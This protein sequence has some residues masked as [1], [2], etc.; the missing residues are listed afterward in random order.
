MSNRRFFAICSFMLLLSLACSSCSTAKDTI[1]SDVQS[2]PPTTASDSTT[3]MDDSE[4]ISTASFVKAG[5]GPL[6]SLDSGI[7]EAQIV[8]ENSCSIFYT[9]PIQQKRIYLCGAPNCTHDNESCSAY[10]STPGRTYPPML[11]TN[12]KK[13]LLMFTEALE[14]S[15][16]SMISIDLDGSNRQTVFELASN[17]YVRGNFYISND[18]IYFDV[19]QT[20]S[21]SSS[22]YQLW[23][24]NIESKEA[25]EVAD[26]GSDEQFYYL[27]GCAGS[28]LCFATIDS[29]SNIKYYLSTPQELNFDAPFYTDNSGHADSFVSNGF[30]YTISEEGECV[31]RT[32]LISGEKRVTAFPIKEGYSDPA[33]QYAYDNNLLVTEG[34]PVVNGKFDVCAYYIDF[35][36]DTATEISLRTPYNNRPVYVYATVG[37]KLY[38]ATDY[39]TYTVKQSFQDGGSE[40]YEYIAYEYAFILKK[41]YV[42]SNDAGY[43][44]VEDMFD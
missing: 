29:N 28:R 16:P 4:P 1:S 2:T 13:I 35:D 17:Q 23:H 9:D 32:N 19:V 26:L 6:V 14:G 44:M 15:N 10:F 7:Y 21:D 24:A 5:N 30:L 37:D 27:C 43:E 31:T 34:S 36:N 20:D 33:M 38:V 18:D 22:H 25:Q 41:D 12:G 40:N 11:L 42:N 39:K 3:L 8:Y